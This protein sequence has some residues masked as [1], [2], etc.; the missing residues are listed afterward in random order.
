MSRTLN[1]TVCKF[2]ES[3]TYNRQYR[4]PLHTTVDSQAINAIGEATDYGRSVTPEAI[5]HVAGHI[6]APR[7]E[8]ESEVLMTNG[9]E[10]NRCRFLIEVTLNELNGGR[11]RKVITGWTSHLGITQ[12]GAVDPNMLLHVNNVIDIRDITH[13]RADGRMETISNI[14]DSSHILFGRFDRRGYGNDYSLRPEDIHRHS[15]TASLINDYGTQGDVYNLRSS[16]ANGIKKT[17]RNNA[18]PTSF[19]SKMLQADNVAHELADSQLDTPDS[20]AKRAAALVRDPQTHLDPVISALDELCDFT[21]QGMFTYGQLMQLAPGIDEHVTEAHFVGGVHK[22]HDVHRAGMTEN[23]HGANVETMIATM[24]SNM[25]PSMMID[26]A[27]NKLDLTATNNTLDGRPIADVAPNGTALSI[28]HGL[29]MHRQVSMFFRKF[30]IEVWPVLS[31]NDQLSLS[32]EVRCDTLADTFIG[33]SVNGGP[34][35]DYV[36]P[37]FCDT[38]MSPI[39]TSDVSAID[40]VTRDFQNIASNIR[41]EPHER[42][43]PTPQIYTGSGTSGRRNSRW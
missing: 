16:F 33:V 43:E 22:R 37:T 35:I 5:A 24:L 30:L 28:I 17:R 19:V 25:V 1:V 21:T 38:L 2:F 8:V 7:A 4:R 10:D 42:A 29:D 12:S 26:L 39:I 31:H 14:V 11:L 9:W 27:I 3:G 32:I 13:R 36:A 23:W 18:L 20:I 34:I 41:F 6:V 15:S 40:N